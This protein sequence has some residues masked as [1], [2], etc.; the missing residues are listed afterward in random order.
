MIP[1]GAHVQSLRKGDIIFN[2][3]QTKELVKYGKVTSGGGRGRIALANGTAYNAINALSNG[4]GGGSFQGGAA[5]NKLGG[6]NSGDSGDKGGGSDTSKTETALDKLKKKFKEFFDWIEVKLNSL[7][8]KIDLNTAKSEN[9]VGYSKKNKYLTKSQDDTQLLIDANKE[10]QKRYKKQADD[11]YKEYMKL[12]DSD[13]SASNKKQLKSAYS[14]LKKGGDIDIASY[15]EDVQEA[16]SELQKWY[17]KSE[18]CKLSAEQLQQQLREIAQTKMDNITEQFESQISLIEHEANMINGF[19][20][21]AELKGYMQS[22]KYYDALKTNA[23]SQKSDLTKERDALAKTLQESVDKGIIKVGSVEFNNMQSQINETTEKIQD[24]DTQILEFNNHIREI[25]WGRFDKK[26]ESVSRINQESDFLIELMSNKDLFDDKGKTTDQGLATMGLHG[27][28]Y[29]VNM[30]QANQYRDEMLRINEELAKDPNNTKL[31]ERRNELLDLQRES[32]LAAESEK[33]AIK[34][35]VEEGIKKELDSLKDLIDTYLDALDSQKSLFDYQK[36]IANQTNEISSLEKQLSVYKNDNSEEGRLKSQ[37]LENQLKEAR[38]KLEETEY[39]KYI[40]DQKKLLDDLYNE[41][42][43]VLNQ[44]LENIDQLIS[45][46]I[47]SVNDNFSSIADTLHEE[48]ES[49]GYTLTQEMEQ[50]WNGEGSAT[51]ILSTYSE[52]FSSTMTTVQE[53]IDKISE[54]IDKM[55]NDS[56]KQADEDIDIS[57][58]GNEQNPTVGGKTP[59]SDEDK[60]EHE[61]KDDG[62]KKKPSKSSQGDGK[63]QVGDKVK[64]VSG[65]YYETPYGTGNSGYQK[66]GSYVYI[67]KVASSGSK[68]YHIST[69]NKLGKGDLGWL[70]KSQI[71]GYASG[72]YNIRKDE[73]AWTQ[74][75][76]K[77]NPNKSEIIIE[78]SGRMLTRSSDGAMLMHIA[79]GTSVLNGTASKNMYNF[80]NDPSKFISGLGVGHF[81][82][83]GLRDTVNQNVS[84]TNE[85]SFTL[86]NV[87]NYEDMVN[88]MQNDT[89]IRKSIQDITIGAINGKNINIRN[90]HR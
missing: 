42:S 35:L 26:Q 44:R 23:T 39:D 41:Y 74:E 56:D 64:F 3:E 75:G 38:E 61:K 52:K 20:D 19:V 34:S 80:A 76:S 66:R 67:T 58:G 18:E 77:Q 89:R 60:K 90:K 22:T 87:M 48:A 1:G 37:Q 73:L 21:Q 57:K 12:G 70:T 50:I 4:G 24:M 14:L 79:K 27:V 63:I 46:V 81:S 86:P 55:V 51:Q 53:T 43:D 29:N 6:N 17:D 13:F 30:E 49:V 31:I 7:Q 68:K 32:I 65:K 8:K 59:T 9:S 5:G 72:A 25:E 88:K 84:V 11:V 36:N 40:S 62:E 2:H 33:Q 83:S 54:G 10:G 78:P 45:D 16:L 69:G 71:S 47:Q 15:D 28:N 82:T 85:I